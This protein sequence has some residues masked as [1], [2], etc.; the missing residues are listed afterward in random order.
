MRIDP[1]TQIDFYKADHRRQY[2]EGTTKV[3][4]N[5]TPRS[6][7]LAKVG[8]H[9][10]DK[11][12]FFGLQGW[13]KWFLKDIW[14]R[15]FFHQPKKEVVER[16]RRR[17]DTALGPGAIPVDHIAALHDLGFLPLKIKALPE[18]SRVNM[19]VPVLTIENTIPEFFWLTNYLESVMSA[20]LW[21]P[22]TSAT[23]AYEYRKLLMKYAH[24]TGSPVEFV[25]FQ[26]HDFS[27]RGLSGLHDAHS[28]GAGHLLS[29][30][31]TDT[32]PAIDYLENYYHAD[33]ER[34][35]VGT[36]VPATEHSVASMG[37]MGEAVTEIEE[38]YDEEIEEWVTLEYNPS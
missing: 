20:E 13:I 22:C 6:N 4:S 16:Y 3:Y 5:F 25:D 8:P 17:M 26:G 37:I 14:N 32:V 1:L 28:S 34:E 36:S 31:G 38:Y 35:I 9:H 18:G 21:K 30:V 19:R 29:F 23:T 33:P 27:F 15:E 24:M 2:P 12:V 11:V 10:D 7:H